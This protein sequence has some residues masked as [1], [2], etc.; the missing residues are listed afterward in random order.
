MGYMT[1]LGIRDVTVLSI[2]R[3]GGDMSVSM[4]SWTCE[5]MMM[6]NDRFSEQ[7]KVR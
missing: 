1:L 3:Y 5:M 4:T 7:K 6:S 2:L